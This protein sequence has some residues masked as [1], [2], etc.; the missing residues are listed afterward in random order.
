M[1]AP[2]SLTALPRTGGG[3]VLNAWDTLEEI[4]AFA[5]MSG[6]KFACNLAAQARREAQRLAASQQTAVSN[7][8]KT[9]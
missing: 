5:G 8:P 6:Y 9:P 2:A 4:P 7:S 3:L 1:I